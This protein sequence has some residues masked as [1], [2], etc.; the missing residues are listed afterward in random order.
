[1]RFSFGLAR[2]VFAHAQRLDLIT[3]LRQKSSTLAVIGE[4]SDLRREWSGLS[5]DS[6]R[7]G[8]RLTAYSS[9]S[10]P[11]HGAVEIPESPHRA[12]HGAALFLRLRG[13]FLRHNSSLNFTSDFFQNVFQRDD[14]H[15]SP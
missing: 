3:F 14:A 7:T 8:N 13:Q 4:A 15:Q 1:M 5:L 11:I 10:F 2:K 12:H 9:G 6:R